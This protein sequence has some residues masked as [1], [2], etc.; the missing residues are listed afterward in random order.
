MK[1]HLCGWPPGNNI[2]CLKGEP[3][4]TLHGGSE[5]IRSELGV[6]C[7]LGRPGKGLGQILHARKGKKNGGKSLGRAR[8]G[9]GQIFHVAKGKREEKRLRKH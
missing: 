6:E 4:R 1:L 8:K 5:E 2:W 7:S 3:F 9:L